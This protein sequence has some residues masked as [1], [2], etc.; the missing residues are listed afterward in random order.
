NITTYRCKGNLK[1]S[2]Y[3]SGENIEDEYLDEI[4]D[5]FMRINKSR[6]YSDNRVGLG[7]SI[8]REIINLHDGKCGV[9]NK[10]DGVEF[11]FELKL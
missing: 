9:L 10:K 2:I 6:T 7:L 5:S 8:I 1:V 4:W 3:N 11:W